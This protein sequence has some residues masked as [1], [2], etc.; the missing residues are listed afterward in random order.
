MSKAI[1]ILLFIT[2]IILISCTEEE[3]FHDQEYPTIVNELTTEEINQRLISLSE[4]QLSKVSNEYTG[5]ANELIKHT[6]NGLQAIIKSP[7][8]SPAEVEQAK[9]D[10]ESLFGYGEVVSQTKMSPEFQK[11]SEDYATNAATTLS[12][13][14]A[15][16]LST[17]KVK[18]GDSSSLYVAG[19]KSYFKILLIILIQK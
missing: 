6:Y 17:A 15:A 3:D 16:T 12:G 4:S 7:N 19:S 9:K 1:S 13:A 18:R 2:S 11:A 14:V 5:T 8:S 10:M